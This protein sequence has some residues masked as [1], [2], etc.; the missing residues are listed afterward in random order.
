MHLTWIDFAVIAAYIGSLPLI[1]MYFSRR[2]VS[3]E[4]YLLG[5][6][7]IHWLL[8][9]GSVVATLVSTLT[10]LAVPGE[11][12][13]YGLAYFT[14]VLALPLAVPVMTR[15]LLPKLMTL[16]ITSMY[17]YLE[18]RYDVQVRVLAAVVFVIRTVVWMGL[19]IYSCSFAIAEMTQW[20]IYW[21]IVITGLI[22]TFYSSA[23]GL[24]TVIW[25]DNLQLVVL[26]GGAVAI[27]LAVLLRTGTGPLEWWSAFAEAGRTQ[28]QFV[29]LDLTVRL[30]VI[31]IMLSQFFWSVCTNGSD[32]VAVQRYLST[33]S[34]RM[35]SRTAWVYIAINVGLLAV[36]SVCGL[37]LFGFYF[38]QS[39]LP[40]S[41]FQREIAPHADALM[42]RFIVKELPQGV[43]G[44]VLA[45]LLAAAMSSLSSGINSLAAVVM[46]D[47]VERFGR[48][49]TEASSLTLTKLVSVAGGLIGIA[50]A[51]AITW[52]VRRSDWN[53]IDV[54]QRLN[55]IFVGPLAVLFFAGI[56]FP[57]ASKRS[58]LA[59]FLAG[60]ACS[61]YV[62]FGRGQSISFTWLVPASFVVGFVIAAVL[63]RLRTEKVP[64]GG[65]AAVE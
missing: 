50:T 18:G 52:A 45:A 25:T 55:H 19:I 51:V 30:T 3:R 62:A 36:L 40:V 23:G 2:Q 37:A 11:I 39:G 26:I 43:S 49:R 60:T 24:R 13:R 57:F 28:I 33:P 4:E 56:L 53:L 10:F 38:Q 6:R 34:I 61:L 14:G 9:A 15:I 59:G 48:H 41:D 44:L 42:P 29:S 54:T 17:E 65:S 22:T 58:V 63:G 7:N 32:Q 21:T 12:V 64:A 16:R 47:L 1:G 8:A 35:A 46:K 5:S 27:P 20:D 31:G